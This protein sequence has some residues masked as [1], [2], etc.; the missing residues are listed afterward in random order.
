MPRLTKSDPKYT[1]HKQSGQARVRI[2][3]RDILLGKYN[4]KASREEYDRIVGEWKTNN[5]QFPVPADQVTVGEVMVAYANHAQQYY[6]KNGG[7]TD[8]VRLI[9]AALKHVRKLYNRTPAVNFGPVAV[10]SVQGSMIDADWCRTHINKQISRIRRMFRW[11]VGVEMIP[12]S[13]HEAL[14]KLDDL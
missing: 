4:S 2:S 12:A 5:R 6:R 9:K 10:R 8:E 7:M 13:V 1:R 11:V 14:T 3:G